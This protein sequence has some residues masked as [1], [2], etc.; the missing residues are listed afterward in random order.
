MKKL[1]VILLLCWCSVAVAADVTVHKLGSVVSGA[2]NVTIIAE[3]N[4][5]TLTFDN[6]NVEFEATDATQRTW[7][8]TSAKAGNITL[9]IEEDLTI[10]DGYAIT[11]AAEDAAGSITLDNAL[12]EIESTDGTQRTFKITS[13]K[14]GN[15]TVTLYEN[16]TIGDGYDGTLTYTA[17]GKTLSVWTDSTIDQNIS[18]GSTVQ[19]AGINSTPI[20]A[21]TPA[22]ATFTEVAFTTVIG[23]P[24]FI[25]AVTIGDGED[26]II[27]HLNNDK[28]TD[29]TYSG[30][31]ITLTV[32]SGASTSFGQAMHVDTDGELIVADA[33]VVASGA[34]PAIGLVVETGV[35]A[36]KVLIHG[37]IVET[38]WNWTTGGAIYVS[39]D[40]TTTEGLTQTAPTA[41]GSTVQF[42]GTALSADSILVQPDMTL[43]IN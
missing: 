35:G 31:I 21:S 8:L 2:K 4:S 33:D 32:D 24:S 19:W 20:G 26:K 3:D 12:L 10:S 39:A 29:G 11:L 5:T 17:S 9:T 37:I 22:T 1:L 16:F 7:K 38:D 15:T 25:G 34:M 6:V 14:A 27:T 43:I 28:T 23:D 40:P 30:I 36:K 13:S 41:S 42:I 18:S